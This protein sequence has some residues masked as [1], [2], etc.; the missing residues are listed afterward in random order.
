[1]SEHK[2]IVNDELWELFKNAPK[3]MAKPAPYPSI[4]HYLDQAREGLRARFKPDLGD[5]GAMSDRDLS[6]ALHLGPS[7]VSNY[8]TKRA[9]PSDSAMVEI[10]LLG[11]EDPAL[12]LLALNEWRAKTIEAKV[13][14]RYLGRKF[15]E[16]AAVIL[17]AILLAFSSLPASAMDGASKIGTNVYYGKYCIDK[18]PYNLSALTG[19]N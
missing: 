19:A 5:I 4:D 18:F 14:Y 16:S 8:R 11:G 2:F 13:A 3:E 9:W 7:A 6:F 17:A 10:A 12:A 1:M 15:R